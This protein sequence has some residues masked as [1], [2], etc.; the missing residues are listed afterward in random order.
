MNLIITKDG[1]QIDH[2]DR[3]KGQPIS[4]LPNEEGGLR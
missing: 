4:R 2:K 1:T 3:G